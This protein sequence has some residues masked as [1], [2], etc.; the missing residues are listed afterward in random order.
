MYT[1][2]MGHV[3]NIYVLRIKVSYGLLLHAHCLLYV[4]PV[5]PYIVFAHLV[6]ILSSPLMQLRM[7]C[8]CF[9]TSP[10]LPCSKKRMNMRFCWRKTIELYTRPERTYYCI[11]SYFIN[12]MSLV[13]HPAN[14]AVVLV[15][16][17][18]HCL[19]NYLR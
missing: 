19:I 13:S 16:S 12:T 5:G 10:V 9:L 14:S 8:C 18:I 4:C 11:V 17:S 7:F 1:T 2:L 6:I 3:Y 15:H